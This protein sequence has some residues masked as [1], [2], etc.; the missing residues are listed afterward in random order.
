MCLCVTETGE[1][2]E[3]ELSVMLSVSGAGCDKRG[4]GWYLSPPLSLSHTHKTGE[5][6]PV[7]FPSA[8]HECTQRRCAGVRSPT[9]RQPFVGGISGQMDD[10][11]NTDDK[12]LGEIH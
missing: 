2:K 10:R 12:T 5:K 6:D 1:R 4:S 9:E 7:V 8:T 3:G 11:G